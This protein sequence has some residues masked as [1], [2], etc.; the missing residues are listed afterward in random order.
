MEKF[1]CKRFFAQDIFQSERDDFYLSSFRLNEEC[2]C[3]RIHLKKFR[4]LT[5]MTY[6]F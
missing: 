6:L 3:Y 1:C 2:E 4:F 5:S